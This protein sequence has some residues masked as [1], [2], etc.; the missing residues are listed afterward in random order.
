MINNMLSTQTVKS[1]RRNF[2][3][4]AALLM[5]LGCQSSPSTDANNKTSK[6]SAELEIATEEQ[7]KDENNR[8]DDV[9]K[10]DSL[11]ASPTQ[12]P[13]DSATQQKSSFPQIVALLPFN[14][15]VNMSDDT[16]HMLHEAVHSHLSSTNYMLVKSQEVNQRLSLFD[17]ENIYLEEDAP[18]LASLLETDAVIIGTV[19]NSSAIYAGVAA[20]IYYE[21]KISLV[22]KQGTV[23]W[24]QIFSERS[25]EGGFSVDPFAMLYNLAVTAMHVGKE[26]M[27]AV[28]D[29]IG[30]QV[31]QAIPQPEGVF[32]R[33]NFFIDSVIHDGVNKVLKY[34]DTVKVG[35]KAATN[36]Q[37]KVSIESVMTTYTAKEGQESGTYFVDIPINSGWN[38]ENLLL[39]AFI[40]DSFGNRVSKISTLGLLHF[41][42]ISP[43]IVNNIGLDFNVNDIDIS[44]SSDDDSLMYSVYSITDGESML[45]ETTAN[46]QINFSY[47]LTPFSSY[48]FAVEAI[49]KAG[50]RSQRLVQSAK[51]LP[52]NALK[53]ALVLSRAKLPTDI[54]QD[55]RLTSAN[56]PYLID[57][58]TRVKA[59]VSLFIDPGVI[60]EF[61]QSG[62]LLIEGALHTFGQQP[63]L[64]TSINKRPSDDTF[65]KINSQRHVELNGFRIENAGIAIEILGGKPIL[66][67]GEIIDS[68]FSAISVR[69]RSNVELSHCL[70]NGS[71][72][73]AIVVS[74]NARLSIKSCKFMQNFPFHIQNSSTY[75]V[76]ARDNQWL[77]AADATT[78][79]GNVTY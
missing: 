59:S 44:W 34:G 70:I 18:K 10:Q 27:F 17:P 69:N 60:I 23:L 77:P 56:S 57:G 3:T 52:S 1:Y 73:S 61:A 66:N 32:S 14:A 74:D 72:M 33:A 62:V 41:D 24:S 28:A 53:Q 38:G 21:V 64:M 29:K 78:I 43:S 48:T 15:P 30:R 35:I 8:V 2:M 51:Y 40:N 58:Q 16:T 42:N 45:I 20:Q 36:M 49:D 39:T 7:M 12:V 22:D 19:I 71:N 11:F 54:T 50:N 5:L 47:Q 26:N 68:K 63:I 37:V 46:T 9:Q 55:M 25:I 76:D 75:F 67:N 13:L 31:A 65:I 6:S 79:L 4:T